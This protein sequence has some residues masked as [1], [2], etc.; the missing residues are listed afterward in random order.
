MTEL[1]GYTIKLANQTGGKA[2]KGHNKTS[3]VQVIKDGCLVKQFRYTVDNP[4]SFMEASRKAIEFAN[5][6]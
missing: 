5:R 6:D 2:G 3:T 1:N 4:A